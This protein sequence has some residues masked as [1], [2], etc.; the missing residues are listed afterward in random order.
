MKATTGCHCP[1]VVD[2]AAKLL[3]GDTYISTML[4]IWVRTYNLRHGAKIIVL[5]QTIVLV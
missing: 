2:V 4:A 3:E 1:G 5:H